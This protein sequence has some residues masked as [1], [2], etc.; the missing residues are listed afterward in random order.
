MYELRN[1]KLRWK[2]S[3]TSGN[4]DEWFRALNK[5]LKGMK[6][7]KI[8]IKYI[9]NTESKKAFKPIT[10][11]MQPMST[12]QDVLNEIKNRFPDDA[13]LT[14]SFGHKG[15]DK[16]QALKELEQDKTCELDLRSTEPPSQQIFVCAMLTQTPPH[17]DTL[18]NIALTDKIKDVKNKIKNQELTNIAPNSQQLIFND[19][20]LQDGYTLNDYDINYGDCLFLYQKLF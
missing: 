11:Q 8:T 10:L 16:G 19:K 7:I 5:L 12:I 17:T 20:R 14:L 6:D 1:D 9:N 15:V 3:P 18:Q 4:A 2:L 13:K